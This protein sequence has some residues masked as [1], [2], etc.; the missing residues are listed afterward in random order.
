MFF[1][2]FERWTESADPLRERC[3]GCPIRVLFCHPRQRIYRRL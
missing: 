2:D 1:E 3:P